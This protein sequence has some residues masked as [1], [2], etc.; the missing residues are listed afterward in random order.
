MFSH[1]QEIMTQI[2][3]IEEKV[4]VLED[5][6]DGD[7]PEAFEDLFDRIETIKKL[8]GWGDNTEGQN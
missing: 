4:V 6:A 7:E 5:Y 1:Q 3:Y 2:E 8:C